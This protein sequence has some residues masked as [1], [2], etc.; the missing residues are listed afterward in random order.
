MY[1]LGCSVIYKEKINMRYKDSIGL[2]FS[3]LTV[4]GKLD[5]KVRDGEIE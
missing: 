2:K 1:L 4:L 3:R 5:N